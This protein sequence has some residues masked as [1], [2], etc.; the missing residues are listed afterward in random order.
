MSLPSWTQIWAQSYDRKNED[1]FA[2]ERD[3]A[4]AIVGAFTTQQLRVQIQS[5]RRKPTSS[6]DA[7]GLV[8]KARS[9]VLD[10]TKEGLSGAIEPLK[11]AI[12]LDP[13][14]AAAHATLGWVLA[15]W[16]VNGLS[17]DP[18]RDEAM[19]RDAAT[20]ALAI[21]PQDPFILK[22][23]SLVWTYCAEHRQAIHCLRKAVEYAP[24]DFSAWGYM[25]WPLTVTADPAD[26]RE[27]RGILDRLLAI[28]P[29]HPGVAFWLYHRSVADTCEGNYGSALD[30]AE[31][32]TE[33]RPSLSLAWMH[34][35][36]VLGQQD[37]KDK[38]LQA[39]QRC[40]NVNPAMTPRHFASLIEKTVSNKDVIEHRLGGL[41]GIGAL[42]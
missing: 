16:L 1:L 5:A 20:K 30:F 22:M 41:R 35:A 29:Q 8:Q 38:A 33:L 21:A 36:N 18:S 10:Y 28:D 31:S 15:E 42:R 40:K 13:S 37:L 39:V 26:L 25:G 32:S 23:V 34:Y 24:F 19:A 6:L 4:G 14:Y 11:R 27:L 12:D 9:Y 17:T 7:W 3:I 2:I